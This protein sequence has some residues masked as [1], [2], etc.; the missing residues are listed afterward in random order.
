MDD[1]ISVLIADDNIEFGNILREYLDNCG[2]LIVKGIARDGLET[3]GMLKEHTPDVVILDLIMPNLDGIGVLERVRSLQLKIKP[4]I[5][6]LS[7]VGQDGFIQKA[8]QLGAE[9]YMVKPFD[10][11]MLVKRINQLYG[12]RYAKHKINMNIEAMAE[13]GSIHPS[14]YAE[15]RLEIIVTD[16]IR[17]MG[18]LPNNAGFHY[19]REA[20]VL[21][22]ED[23]KVLASVTRNIYPVIAG[24]HNITESQVNRAIRRAIKSSMDKIRKM[25]DKKISSDFNLHKKDTTN[26]RIISSLANKAKLLINK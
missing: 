1:L 2:G 6:V 14:K 11:E 17:N 23:P 9:Y 25:E 5:I 26:A 19:L 8:V 7:A 22:I 24:R 16:Q 20:V 3:I 21:A 12:E 10:A 13:A 18:I 4:I 15:N